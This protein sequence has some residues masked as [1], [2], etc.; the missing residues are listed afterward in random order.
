MPGSPF[1]GSRVPV[2]LPGQPT[3]GALRALAA[4]QDLAEQKNPGI[5]FDSW[6]NDQRDNNLDGVIDDPGEKGPKH[7]D[8]AHKAGTYTAKVSLVPSMTTQFTPDWM[9]STINVIYR[10]CIDI[11][12]MSYTAAKI[13][14]STN[15]WIP[16][17][18]AELKRISGWKVWDGGAKPDTLMDGDIVAARNTSHQHAGLVETG[19]AWDNVIN[20][21]GPTSAM[22]YGV[23]YPSYH[24]DIRSI[25]RSLFEA[26]IGIDLYARWIRET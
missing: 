26:V 5:W 25:P 14:V 11:P 6:Y 17:F 1:V 9:V 24:N 12:I 19:W 8:G 4:A 15:R 23:Y 20:L 7:T 10:V 13:P 18:F 2:T 16:S 21:P 3:K 22:K